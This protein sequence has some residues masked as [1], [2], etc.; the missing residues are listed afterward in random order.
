MSTTDRTSSKSSKMERSKLFTTRR[1]TMSSKLVAKEARRARSQR[2]KV[3][4]LLEH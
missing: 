3:L 1:K 4:Q 2:F